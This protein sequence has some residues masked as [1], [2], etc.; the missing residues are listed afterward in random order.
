MRVGDHDDVEM[1]RFQVLHETLGLGAPADTVR[2]AG[3]DPRDVEVE[4]FAPEIDAIPIESP[5][6]RSK[7]R[8]EGLL[9][10]RHIE[11]TLLSPFTG[12]DG[13]PEMIIEFEI[14]EG[15]IHVQQDRIQ[16]RPIDPL[17]RLA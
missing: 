2:V 12:N 14:E 15:A 1:T 9:A 16:L 11:S 10:S 8:R 5:P 7:E 4:F 3:F 17:H 13:T 6:L